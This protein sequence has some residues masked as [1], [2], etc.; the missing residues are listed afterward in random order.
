MPSFR[1]KDAEED[2]EEAKKATDTAREDERA[3]EEEE[4]K[5]EEESDGD[6][7]ESDHEEGA[8]GGL[9]MGVTIRTKRNHFTICL[10]QLTSTCLFTHEYIKLN[11]EFM[12]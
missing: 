5:S 11:H 4:R 8:A 12:E 1:L 9:E 10:T 6:A 3:R 2:T 7:R